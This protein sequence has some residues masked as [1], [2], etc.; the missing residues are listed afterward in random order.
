MY[1]ILNKKEL[2]LALEINSQEATGIKLYSL[3][4]QNSLIIQNK[5]VSTKNNHEKLT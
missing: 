2:C 3:I 4:N 1:L 5:A